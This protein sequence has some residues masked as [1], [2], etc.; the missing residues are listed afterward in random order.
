MSLRGMGRS[1]AALAVGGAV[2]AVVYW[3]LLNVPESNVWMLGLSILLA[4]GVIAAL[5]VTIGGAAALASEPF[6]RL[7]LRQAIA[8]LPRFVAGLGVFALLWWLTATADTWWA[9]H[10]GEI[11]AVFV[12][13]LNVTHT[14][15]LH[16]AVRWIT[17]L[18]RWGLGLSVIA[19]LASSNAGGWRGWARGLRTSVRVAPLVT[20]SLGAVAVSE[21][22]WQLA[23]WM[24][25]R[26]PPTRMEFVFAA[27]KLSVLCVLAIV[28]AASVLAVSG[29][30]A[31]QTR[32]I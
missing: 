13:Y 14:M 12:R 22:L 30:A 23:F 20:T 8:A 10:H 32:A 19:A 4:L 29:R 25:E 1:M 5:G 11:D 31:R 17:W 3:A 18:A 24:P 21:G 7:A 27:V 9:A 6:S 28:I 15:P 16:T 2:A 26:L